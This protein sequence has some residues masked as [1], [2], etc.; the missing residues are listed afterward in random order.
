MALD[1]SLQPDIFAII[2]INVV[3]DLLINMYELFVMSLA[4]KQN[5]I[6]LYILYTLTL[7]DIRSSDKK[8]CNVKH[9]VI[10][11]NILV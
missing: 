9:E 7:V 11:A 10:M 5:T 8:I 6:L 3:F 2:I 4:S 1:V